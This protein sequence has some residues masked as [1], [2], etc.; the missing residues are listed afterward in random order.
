MNH[1]EI[2]THALIDCGAIGIAFMAQDFAR[3]Y[4]I[5]LQELNDKRHVEVIDRRPT[6]SGDIM[7]VAK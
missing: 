7:H 1:R 3:H 6:E 4:Q 2:P 5:P